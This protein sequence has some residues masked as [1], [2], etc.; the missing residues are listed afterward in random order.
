MNLIVENIHTTEHPFLLM[1][2]KFSW[3]YKTLFALSNKLCHI[4]LQFTQWHFVMLTKEQIFWRKG[5]CQA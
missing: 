5:I 2:Q 4:S 3:C 1:W